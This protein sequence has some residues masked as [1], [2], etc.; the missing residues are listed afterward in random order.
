MEKGVPIRSISRAIAVLQSINRRGSLTMMQIADAAEVPYPT[1]CRIVQTLLFEG[2]IE[3]EPARK[4]YRPTALVQSLSH[5]FQTD[6]RL[7]QVARPHIVALTKKVAWP[8]SIATRV[9]QSM[10]VRDSTHT[11]TSLTLSNY[12]PGFTLP[13]IECASGR[14][15]L[16][17]APDEER[18]SVL[19]GLK[20]LPGDVDPRNLK[21]VQSGSMLE[22]IRQLGYATKGRN[23]YTATPG[24]TSSIA[25]PVFENGEFVGSLTFIFFAVAMK[26]QDAVTLYVDDL[27]KTASDIG[28][29]LSA[30]GLRK[31]S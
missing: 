29:D 23:R 24:R 2:L 22:E 12:Y 15:Y 4:R 16:A 5:G 6:D 31:A 14:C 8:V 21:L 25:V 28:R 26:M 20:T 9:G 27:K 10:M 30:S 19:A 18:E 7:V 3:R 11:L 17:F 13:L 1:A